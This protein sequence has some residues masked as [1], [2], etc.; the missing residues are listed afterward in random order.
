MKRILL[1]TGVGICSAALAVTVILL[2]ATCVFGNHRFAAPTCTEPA[3]CERCG[4]KDGEPLGHVFADATCTEP[5]TCVRCALKQG[6]PLGHVWLDATCTEPETCARCNA[7]QG[8][9]LGHD[10]RSAT[11]QSPAA[12]SRCGHTEGEP[13]P[14]ALDVAS[15]NLLTVGVPAPYTTAS[16]EDYDVDV[17]GTAEIVDYR[18]IEGDETFPACEG[19]EWHIATVR[20]VFSGEDAQQN[21]AQ[22]AY[23]FGDR[24]TLDNSMT[25]GEDENG[26]RLFAADL[27]GVRVQ[28]RHKTGAIL[29][30]DWYDRELRFCWEEG[31]QVPTGY[32]GV[33]LIL[34]N[35]CLAQNATQLFLPASEVLNDNALVFRMD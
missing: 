34:Y 6:E 2:A 12:C 25:V 23:T 27:N 30:N 16:F 1:W 26:M 17:T 13:K 35:Y 31:V 15:L 10:M 14:A 5:Q 32:D 18:V 7:V 3:V 4:R 22:I 28:C 33:L 19:Y 8:D 20:T 29:E 21:G 9:P 11:F 24:Y